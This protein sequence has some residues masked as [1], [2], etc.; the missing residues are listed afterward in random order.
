M[1][2]ISFF[3]FEL[4]SQIQNLERKIDPIFEYDSNINRD[5]FISALVNELNKG[6]CM[7]GESK[8]A[9]VADDDGA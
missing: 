5:D 7:S 3:S 8:G 6:G 2:C 9:D 4:F 1:E